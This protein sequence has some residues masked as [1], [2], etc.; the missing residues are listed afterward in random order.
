MKRSSATT[1]PEVRQPVQAHTSTKPPGP[2]ES[3]QVRRKGVR[4]LL[5]SRPPEKPSISS[6]ETEWPG[7]DWLRGLELSERDWYLGNE[8]RF[9]ELKERYAQVTAEEWAD[10]EATHHAEKTPAESETANN[11]EQVVTPDRFGSHI[12]DLVR[13]TLEKYIL[14]PSKHAV[15]AYTLWIAATHAQAEW[16]HATRFVFKS[17]IKRC[18]KTRAQEIGRELVNRPLSTTNISV[19]ALVRSLDEKDPHT[20]ILDEADTIFGRKAAREGSEDLRGILN[21]GHSRG[22]PYLRWDPKQREMESCPTFAMTLIGGIGDL[23]DTIEDRAVV[24]PMRRRAPGE[25]ISQCRRRDIPKLHEVRDQLHAWVRSIDG[26]ANSEPNMPV[27]DREADVWEPLVAIADAAGGDWPKM[28][29]IACATICAAAN[30]EETTAGE[31]LLADIRDVWG[32]KEHVFSSD[33]IE[34]LHTIDE[35]PWSDWFGHP[36]STRDVSRLLRPYGIRSRNVRDGERQA[37][38]YLRS[39]MT[40]AWR[41]YVTAVP[42]S[43]EP[44]AAGSAWDGS[45]TD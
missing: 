37:K 21:S 6:Q 26:L 7:I 9:A 33:L 20:L 3:T 19:A 34:Q 41:S 39:D 14:F 4:V 36:L 10:L 45:G 12:L 35:A 16:E 22:W 43:Q 23:P 38:G 27:E 40:D 18:G 15:V 25:K 28:S 11:H 24:I 13:A 31:R 8:Q 44:E 42:T 5:D 17:P 2:W 32:D 1:T 30:Q 29:R